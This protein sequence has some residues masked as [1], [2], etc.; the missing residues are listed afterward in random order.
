[1]RSIQCPQYKAPTGVCMNTKSVCTVVASMRGV[2]AGTV[3]DACAAAATGGG[4]WG[5]AASGGQSGYGGGYGGQQGGGPMKNFSQ[6][7]RSAP[8]SSGQRGGGGGYGGGEH[9]RP[10]GPWGGQWFGTEVGS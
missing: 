10:T 3:G 5:G 2:C 7:P 6:T 1:M 8:Y 4:G 9:T